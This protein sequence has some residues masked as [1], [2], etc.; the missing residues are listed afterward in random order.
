MAI[1]I[2]QILNAMQRF[3]SA[4]VILILPPTFEVIKHRLYTIKYGPK[5][6]SIVKRI[7]KAAKDLKM[8]SDPIIRG[9]IG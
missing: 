2:D 3:P 1:D 9:N 6:D 5:N 7:A 8:T 4:N